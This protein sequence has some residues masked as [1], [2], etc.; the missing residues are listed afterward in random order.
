MQR[1]LCPQRMHICFEWQLG[2]IMSLYTALSGFAPANNGAMGVT[3]GS[4]PVVK[5]N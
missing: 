3:Y 1:H 5:L 4:F 2:C